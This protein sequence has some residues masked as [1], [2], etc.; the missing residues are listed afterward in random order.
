MEVFTLIHVAISL[1]G[2]LSGKKMIKIRELG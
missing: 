1:T 2:I